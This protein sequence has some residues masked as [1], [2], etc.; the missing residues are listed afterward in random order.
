MDCQCCTPFCG[1]LAP[2][3][4]PKSDPIFACGVPPAYVH[5]FCYHI[6]IFIGKYCT[7][8]CSNVLLPDASIISFELKHSGTIMQC[9]VQFSSSASDLLCCFVF[10]A[11]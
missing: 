5:D 2:G 7:Y 1:K 6:V 8:E 11:Y 10:A 9:S 3:S 4:G